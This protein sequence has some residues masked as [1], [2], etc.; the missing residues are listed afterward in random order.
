[1][2]R[3]AGASRRIARDAYTWHL[4]LMLGLFGYHQAIL[5]SITPFLRDEMRLTKVDIGWHFS[6]YA[7]G[8]FVAGQLVSILSR[9][10]SNASIETVS[11]WLMIGLVLL[12]A[13]PM[14]MAG[15]LFG[16]LGLGLSVGA[17]QVTSQAAI[18]HRH[19]ANR[20]IAL[21][22]GFVFGAL[23]VFACPLFIG[24][25]IETGLDWRQTLVASA[26]LVGLVFFASRP[27]QASRPAMTD[28]IGM[29]S[30]VG[31]QGRLPP[32]LYLVL[33]MIFLGIA[34]EW[35]IGFWGAQFLEVQLSVSATTGV[36]LMSVFFGGTVLGRL[37]ASRLLRAFELQTMLV[38][39][40]LLGGA[41]VLLLWAVPIF[42]VVAVALAVAGMCLGNFFPLILS[43]ANDVVPERPGAVSAGATQ[44][45][46]F[47]LLVVPLLLGRLGETIGLADAIGLL[48][49]LP[50]IMLVLYGLSTS[51][52]S[53]P[54][55]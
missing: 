46:G 30:A 13:I 7:F 32:A 29:Q 49:L 23:G 21:T 48:A 33:A 45:V 50:L 41:S 52:R 10:F 37:F 28:T 44:A 4:Y 12:F 20:G 39:T 16:A 11:V 34:T 8:L 17:L 42:A 53:R 27:L 26:V 40:I 38:A 47:A 36:T 22:E 54:A 18:A 55:T 24:I 25:S 31:G 5:G 3:A 9:R 43:I 1:M 51:L 6:L 15:T 2:R 14:P 35:G 19:G